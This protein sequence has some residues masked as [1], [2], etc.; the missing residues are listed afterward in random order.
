[1]NLPCR[2]LV[3][4]IQIALE[5]GARVRFTATGSSMVPFLRNGEVVE[6]E[7]VPAKALRAGDVVLARK[8]NDTYVLHRIRKLRTGEALVASDGGQEDG[9]IPLEDIVARARAVQ[10]KGRWLRLDTAWARTAGLAW[11]HIRF[12]GWPLL[13]MAL[14]LR[15]RAALRRT[16][17]AELDDRPA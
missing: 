9:W 11:N 7:R 12:V 8:E 10:R 14:R 16:A 1:M 4:L 2:E 5:G 6:L 3:P 15:E 13:R 17:A